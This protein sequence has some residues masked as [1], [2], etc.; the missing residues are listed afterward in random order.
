MSEPLSPIRSTTP[1]D[2]PSDP[3]ISADYAGWWQ[4]NK[5]LFQVY[6]R[7]LALLQCVGAVA[8][9]VLRIPAAL[10]QAIQTR[11][12][13]DSG[14]LDSAEIRHAIA[15]ALP[16]LT[17]GTVGSIL[18]GLVLALISLAGMRLLVT[19]VTGGQPSIPD[20]LRGALGRLLPLVG[21]SL[22]A[23]LILLVGFCAC[24]VPAVYFAGVFTVLPAVVLFER[25]GVIVRCFKLFHGDFG[26]SIARV[27]TV[28]GVAI[29]VSLLSS[30]VG[31]IV[32][33]V[34]RAWSAGTGGLV[35]GTVISTLF[36]V[37]ITAALGVLLTP[38]VLTT[39]ADER[40][41]LEPLHTGVLAHELAPAQQ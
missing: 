23:G 34:A 39:Y 14:Q 26:A 15:A 13:R 28:I 25:G 38:L 32:T 18:A 36:Q 9:L 3:L 37:A 24:F 6:W 2:D 22:L 11:G 40:A 29:A 1:F 27:A 4:K 19:G 31:T 10:V 17:I 5:N 35:S 7:Q 30:S 12:L 16:A 21:W 33:T 8:A 41:R 20:A